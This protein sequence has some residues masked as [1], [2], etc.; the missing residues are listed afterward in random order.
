MTAPCFLVRRHGR[1]SSVNSAYHQ[2]GRQLSRT[3]AKYS[4]FL[5]LGTTAP[6]R[7]R[8]RN[9]RFGSGQSTH[10]IQRHPLRHG[11]SA[12]TGGRSR[13]IYTKD[14]SHVREWAIFREEMK[15]I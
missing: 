11:S 6:A 4:L 14:C 12:G 15:L 7:D 8:R 1:A 13:N 5:A 10:G 2:A 3:Q 9:H